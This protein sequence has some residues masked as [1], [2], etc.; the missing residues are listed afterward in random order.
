MQTKL[1]KVQFKPWELVVA[2]VE[3][4]AKIPALPPNLIIQWIEVG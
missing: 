4:F 1:T 3:A 2:S